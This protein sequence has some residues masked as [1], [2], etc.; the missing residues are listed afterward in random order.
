MFRTWHRRTVPKLLSPAPEREPSAATAASASPPPLPGAPA[1][2]SPPRAP[3]RKVTASSAPCRTISR[4]RRRRQQRPPRRQRSRREEAG[5]GRGGEARPR[6]IP[7]RAR[8]ASQAR[9][10]P[11]FVRSGAPATGS[12]PG[13]PGF[14][15]YADGACSRGTGTPGHQHPLALL[16]P[17]R[18]GRVA[19]YCR[20]RAPEAQEVLTFGS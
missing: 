9:A 7:P 18:C 14:S 20:G 2:R 4:R 13:V 12:S 1:A 17:R 16:R 5:A 15:S 10:A 11:G 8:P 6:R 3:P 19:E